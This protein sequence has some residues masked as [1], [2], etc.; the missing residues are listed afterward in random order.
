MIVTVPKYGD[1]KITEPVEVQ[2]VA[3]SSGK[4]SEPQPFTY[5][6]GMCNIHYSVLPFHFNNQS[7]SLIHGMRT[8]RYVIHVT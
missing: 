6:P 7:K 5:K 2:I 8:Q 4:R 3:E 1:G